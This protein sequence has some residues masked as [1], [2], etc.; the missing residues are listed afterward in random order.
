MFGGGKFGGGKRRAWRQ[1]Q[2]ITRE[3]GVVSFSAMAIIGDEK[4]HIGLGVGKAGETLPSRDKAT[5]KA[6][7]DIM[8]IT[9]GCAS[10]DCNC[11]H[12]TRVISVN[13]LV[14][15]MVISLLLSNLVNAVRIC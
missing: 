1:T 6:K 14:V 3:G 8:R 15:L 4:G 5:R 13:L 12:F 10:F 11:S 9:R 2:R 7:K